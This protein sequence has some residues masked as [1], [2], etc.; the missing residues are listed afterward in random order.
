MDGMKAQWVVNFRRSRGKGSRG[1]DAFE[2]VA[3]A[4]VG[5]SGKGGTDTAEWEPTQCQ[6]LER[7]DTIIGK[8]VKINA[9]LRQ[10]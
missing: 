4:D 6:S 9:K 10:R 8:K 7:R 5:P 2:S 1:M 3:Q